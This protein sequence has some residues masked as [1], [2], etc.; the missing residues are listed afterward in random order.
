MLRIYQSTNSFDAVKYYTDSL[1]KQDYYTEGQEIVGLWQGLAAERMGLSGRV[2]QKSFAL[3]CKN[4]NPISGAKLTP[5]TRDDRTVGYDVNF[6]APKGISVL[7]ALT[8]D[9]RIV[10]VMQEAVTET[11]REMEQSLHTRVRLEG[12]SEDRHTGNLVWGEFTHF[13][14][15]PV[16]GVP[17]PQLHVHCFAFNATWDDTEL[18]WKAGQFRQLVRDHPYYQGVFHTKLAAKMEGL[19]YPISRAR[20]TWDLKGLSREIVDKYS[21]RTAEIEAAAKR[22]GITDPIEKSQVGA[23]TR[24]RKNKSLSATELA[25]RWQQR[26]DEE[27][28]EYLH[29]ITQGPGIRQRDRESGNSDWQQTYDRRQQMTPAEALEHAI[30]HVY[31]RKAV[32]SDRRLVAEA[33]KVAVGHVQAEDLWATFE[34]HPDL[35]TRQED[36]QRWVTTKA[37]LAEEKAVLKFAVAGKG[38]E[39]PLGAGRGGREGTPYEVGSLAL[40]EGVELNDAQKAAVEHLISSRDR[41]MLLR[42]GAGTGKTTLLREAAMAVQHGGHEVY[43]FAITSDASRN[44]LKKA[45]FK[46][47]VP[48]EKL[49]TD[50]KWQERVKGQVIWV[51]EAG[52]MGTPTMKRLADLA[53]KQDARVV[54]SGDTK[55]HAPVERGDA[56]KLIE[57]RAGIR[58]AEV[59][60]I[61]R[62]TGIYKQAVEALEHGKLTDCVTALDKMGAIKEVRNLE[63]P[64]ERH[65][66]LADRY[67]E[68]I[69]QGQSVVVVSPTH[70]EG[71]EVNEHIRDKLKEMGR[72]DPDS[73]KTL[74]RLQD[75]QWTDAAKAD[76]H[77]YEVGM[78]IGYNQHCPGV[79]E[80]D[81]PP[82]AGGTKAAVVGVDA[83]RGLV[84]TKDIAG[85]LR[86]LPL[87]LADRFQVYE[88]Q[89]MKLAKGDQIRITKGFNTID[90]KHRLTNGS[91]YGIKGFTEEGN[92]VLDNRGKWE[93]HRNAGFMAHAYCITPQVAQGKSVDRTLAA[94]SSMSLSASS[95]E[96]LYVCL[97]RGEKSVEVLT[98][99]RK[100]FV[101][102][103]GKVNKDKMA[104]ELVEPDDGNATKLRM[105]AHAQEVQRMRQAEQKRFEMMRNRKMGRGRET[106]QH[107]DRDWQ[108]DRQQERPRTGNETRKWQQQR[109]GPGERER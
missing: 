42:G 47:A 96:Q 40:R 90:G 27:E 95:L 2:D 102:A 13:T 89:E 22:L 91:T 52:M 54:L 63:E 29:Q 16:D 49:L 99:N 57:R 8:G 83:E 48:L 80:R 76:A 92:L 25:T 55:Q 10:G 41:L 30:G 12:K 88:S 93:I 32:E 74:T 97:S 11:M 34:Q 105:L 6:H 100:A 101:E 3:L 1:S 78:V 60:E 4:Q 35:I 44:T 71:R 17:D 64:D 69:G 104:T 20:G 26:L 94:L 43:A 46:S 82:A 58:P 85:N 14:S 107:P 19:G 56:M 73:E 68:I 5:R 36:G 81:I 79:K 39:L 15:R 38:M 66:Q 59:T 50:Q 103:M 37:V 23:R 62:Q 53:E 109:K 77:N 98:E 106:G 21:R 33:L 18:R 108:Q 24:A 67:G 75:K 86:P 7:H 61:I 9:H 31:E 65:R 72:I 87:N 45:G 28:A 84:T 70:K 51:D